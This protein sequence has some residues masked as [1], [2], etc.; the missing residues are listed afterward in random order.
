MLSEQKIFYLQFHSAPLG[1]APRKSD[2]DLR[3]KIL[4]WNVYGVHVSANVSCYL[5]ENEAAVC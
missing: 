4:R 5:C 1:P 2:L 3:Q